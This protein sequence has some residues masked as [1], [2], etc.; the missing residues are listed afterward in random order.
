MQYTTVANESWQNSERCSAHDLCIPCIQR[1]VEL[2]VLEEGLWNICCPGVGCQYR[3]VDEDIQV[4]LAKSD[5]CNEALEKRA[6]LRSQNFAP[7]MEEVLA[8]HTA[9]KAGTVEA[10]DNSEALLLAECQICPTCSVLVRR[11]GGCTHIV[12]RCS[13]DFCFGCGAPLSDFADE[14]V[15][16]ER[17]DVDSMAEEDDMEGEG[18][19][20]LGFWRQWLQT[21]VSKKQ[22]D[23]TEAPNATA[24]QA[25]DQTMVSY[26]VGPLSA[27]I[28]QVM[29]PPKLLRAKSLP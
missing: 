14:C 20:S 17:P 7:R 22:Q 15:C 4:A 29:E 13:Q 11:E 9:A 10:I 26:D 5:R 8:L 24:P 2:K 23:E 6:K 12:C 21:S 25:E 19:P 18:R 16:H 3:L 1:F 27:V 28:A